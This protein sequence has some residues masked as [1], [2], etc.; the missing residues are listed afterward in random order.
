MPTVSDLHNSAPSPAAAYQR[1]H[2]SIAVPGTPVRAQALPVQERA[3]EKSCEYLR[4]G[5][6]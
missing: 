5:G 4:E 1:H 2:E 3:E 6:Y